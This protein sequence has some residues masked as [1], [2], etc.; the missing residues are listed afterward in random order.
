MRQYETTQICG[1]R[2]K[3][4]DR[5]LQEKEIGTTGCVDLV[6]PISTIKFQTLA[7]FPS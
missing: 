4:I 3:H 7:R 1:E 5:R 6:D 2:G